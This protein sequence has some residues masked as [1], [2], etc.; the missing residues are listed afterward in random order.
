MSNSET[1]AYLYDPNNQAINGLN[2]YDAGTA[3]ESFA[4]T[5]VDHGGATW[6][7]FRFL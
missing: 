7:A 2:A 6:K 3:F 5:A 1:G 4:I